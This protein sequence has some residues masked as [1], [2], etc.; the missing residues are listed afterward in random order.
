MQL[1]CLTLLRLVSNYSLR[2]AFGDN[3]FYYSLGLHE[4]PAVI[5]GRDCCA[6]TASIH[7]NGLPW[8]R[9][10]VVSDHKK[11]GMLGTWARVP[12]YAVLCVTFTF[13]RGI[14]RTLLSK[15]PMKFAGPFPFSSMTD[16]NTSE[17]YAMNPSLMVPDCRCSHSSKKCSICPQKFSE[18]WAVCFSKVSV[19]PLHLQGHA[20]SFKV[21]QVD[22]RAVSLYLLR[23]FREFCSG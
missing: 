6:Y 5:F 21:T 17:W 15:N 13:G 12:L 3:I 20:R 18:S 14:T 23:L 22:K 7:I 16:A 8:I 10:H 19:I 4:I 9:T 1:P 2:V 11:T